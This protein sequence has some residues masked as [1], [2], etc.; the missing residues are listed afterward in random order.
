MKK[1][2]FKFSGFPWF[3]RISILLV[4]M[5]NGF[6]GLAQEKVVTGTVTAAN[7]QPLPGVNIVV[8]GTN[9]GVSA[10]FDGNYSINV[11]DDGNTLVFTYLGFTTQEV[12]VD[13]QDIINVVLEENTA[14]LDEVVVI[15]YGSRDRS[16]LTGAVSTV[17]AASIAEQPVTSFE[18]TLSGQVSGVQLRQN[19]APGAGPEILVR[20][21]ASTGG[22]NAPLYV[23]DGIPL[24]NVNSQ[25]DNFILNSID[26]SSIE[27][28]SILKDASSKAIYGSRASNG[29]I[30]I[31]TKRGKTGK[32]TITFGTSTGFQTVPDFERPK[33]LN[34][35]QLR[36]FRIESFSDQRF[37]TGSLGQ[38]DLA[39][40]DRLILLG[41]LGE[42]TNWFDEITRSAPISQYNIGIN[43]GS[44]NIRYNI[45]TNY[46]NQ[47][48]TLL[49]T[50]FKRYSIRANIDVDI[51]DKLRFGLNLAPTQTLA[52]GGRT[53]AGSDNFNIFAAVPLSRWT[54]PSAPVFREDGSLT[55][56][57]NGDIIPFYNVNPVYLLKGREDDRR[58]NQFLAG[59][60][61]ELDLIKGLTARTF[62]SIQSI[63]RRN[64][65]FE[66]SDFPGDGALTPNLSG[67]RQARTD[68]GEFNNF[69]WVWENTLRYNR[70]IKDVHRF[71]ILAGF[72]ME[73]RRAD[74]T[75]INAKNLIDE[76]IRIPNS[77]NVDP[78]DITNFTGRG[79]AAQNSLISMIGRV[80]Y[81]FKDRYYVTGTIRRDGSSRF[82]QNTRYG[83]F[84]SV[85]GA[86]RVSNESFWE[87]ISNTISELKF[88]GGWGIS[89]SNA[90]IGNYEAQGRING[91]NDYIFGGAIA[92][93]SAVSALPN[94][95]LTW[96]EAEE[97]NLG[98]DLGLF[99]DKV[100]LSADYYDI[101]TKGFLSGL[102]L[103]TTSGFG[104]IL[105][106]LGSI[107][108]KGFELEL[109]WQIFNTD[110]F[111]WNANFNFTKNRSKVL[112][113]AAESGFIR[114]GAIAREFT[115]TRVGEEVGLYRGFNV[116]G[117]FTQAEIDDPNVP[118]Y[119]DAVEGSLKYEDGNG[120]G[121]LGDE[122]DFV[123]IGNPNADF[124]YGMVHNF[125]Y[126]NLD[127]SLVFAGSKG[128]QIFNGTN[129][130]NGNQ[131]GVFNVDTRQLDRWRPGDDPTTKVIPG[132]ASTT[133]RQRFRLPNSLSVDDADYLWVR[134]VT[135]GYNLKGSEIGNFFQNARIYTSIQNPLLFSEYEFGNPEINRSGDTALVRN[136]NYGAFPISRTFSL[137]VNLT[138]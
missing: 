39:E 91:N 129:Q 134:N 109:R 92:P 81:A 65:S 31:T 69:N 93:G 133:S 89:G 33:V 100:Y 104:N 6:Y 24:G 46:T 56:V 16:D 124:N 9:I 67:T 111:G 62:G 59:S 20:G 29:V 73:R 28:I 40:L 38:G 4:L 61:I 95:L 30:I 99:N 79:E 112:E 74:N 2:Q 17:Q 25:R 3:S 87:G 54:D 32:P 107:E 131:D 127:L 126:K 102:P 27:S 19:G 103:P 43:G 75:I 57:A 37:A 47:D 77:N 10:D 83:N 108:N 45:A 116:T 101:E 119:P 41:D 50:N 48:G 15:G 94:S 118:K 80:D 1:K 8:K 125:R 64:T 21:V 63:D 121:V 71:D 36:R 66:P 97:I 120:D 5:L 13:G 88:E 72:T 76:S 84:P 60:F 82:G 34:A 98:I 117:L 51:S 113:L 122:E 137:G 78:E 136:V 123:I 18:Q 35:E 58:T 110:N 96:E 53:D 114:R 138:F 90:N 128:Q 23:V 22:N 12:S 14:E 106:N 42:G 130:Y 52:T 86:W 68:V 105:T 55:N 135:F 132:T 115:E 26:P 44:D 7:G 11:P 85:A 70:V 49:N